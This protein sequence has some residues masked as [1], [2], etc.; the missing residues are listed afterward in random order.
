M[1][2]GFE[3]KKHGNSIVTESIRSDEEKN[4]VWKRQVRGY[5]D[6]HVIGNPVIHLVPSELSFRFCSSFNHGTLNVKVI[7]IP[8]Q[9]MRWS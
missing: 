8:N 5:E 1:K 3:G 7:V 9:L 2:Y 4:A 6:K